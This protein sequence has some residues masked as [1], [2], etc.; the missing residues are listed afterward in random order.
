ML[1]DLLESLAAGR[2]VGGAF[3]FVLDERF[4]RVLRNGLES[5]LLLAAL[6]HAHGHPGAALLAQPSLQ[7]VQVRRKGVDED[8]LRDGVGVESGI[9]L[10]QVIRGQFRGCVIIGAFDDPAALAADA[11]L[12]DMEDLDGGFELFG[13]EGE[14]IAVGTDGED[15]GRLV[16]DLLQGRDL[17]A[18][19][20]RSFVVEFGCRVGHL[21]LPVADEATGVA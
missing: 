14:D 17:V 4:L 15:H 10:S 13:D 11:T 18:Q 12:A 19:T 5:R 9:R 2:Q 7:G 20:G 1:L 8:L 3:E 16:E 21:L 6:G